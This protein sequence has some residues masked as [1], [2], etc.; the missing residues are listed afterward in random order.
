MQ[1]PFPITFLLFLAI[2]PMND[3]LFLE[4]IGKKLKI[5]VCSIVPSP[6]INRIHTAKEPGVSNPDGQPI[7][8]VAK[9][10]INH[11]QI[12]GSS[13]NLIIET[14]LKDSFKI[15]TLID[16]NLKSSQ[17]SAEDIVKFRFHRKQNMEMVR[18]QRIL[19]DSNSRI[20]R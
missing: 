17:F 1:P 19:I 12:S 11:I 6:D 4:R 7:R 2:G 14:L 16:H 13:Q 8:I 15:S 10:V 3:N 20:D 9:I 18:H 5:A